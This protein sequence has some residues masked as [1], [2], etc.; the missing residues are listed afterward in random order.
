MARNELKSFQMQKDWKGDL[1]LKPVRGRLGGLLPGCWNKN[2]VCPLNK[3]NF[4]V[5][6]FLAPF[7]RS[8]NKK[9]VSNLFSLRSFSSSVENIVYTKSKSI[10]LARSNNMFETGWTIIFDEMRFARIFLQRLRRLCRGWN[11]NCPECAH[12]GTCAHVGCVCVCV[13]G[14]R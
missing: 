10:R 1:L 6:S 13:F 8:P 3:T 9:L 11:L 14:L 5:F 7:A 4:G 12:V 2:V